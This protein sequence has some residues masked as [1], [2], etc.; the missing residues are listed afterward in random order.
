[1]RPLLVL[2]CVLAVA[3]CDPSTPT[4]TTMDPLASTTTLADD[5]CDRVATDTA[6]Y[7]ELTVAV[8]DETTLDEFR[9]RE[10]WPEPLLALEEQGEILDS[11]ADRL[12]CDPARIQ[13]DAFAQARLEPKSG[14]SQYLLELWGLEE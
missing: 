8:L 12:R 9:D 5:T 10:A 2:L 1:V 3:A 7:L 14:L 13:A 6:R 11:R 4:L